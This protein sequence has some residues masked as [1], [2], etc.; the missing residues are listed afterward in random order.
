MNPVIFISKIINP[1]DVTVALVE[2]IFDI[3]IFVMVIVKI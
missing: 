2:P 3:G 1:I